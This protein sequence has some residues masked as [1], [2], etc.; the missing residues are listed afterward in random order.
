MPTVLPFK[1][2]NLPSISEKHDPE[3]STTLSAGEESIRDE[4]L[5]PLLQNLAQINADASEDFRTV[6]FCVNKVIPRRANL[7]SAWQRE[8][9]KGDW[10]E[11]H[12]E[13]K[14]LKKE[15]STFANEIICVIDRLVNRIGPILESNHSPDDKRACLRAFIADVKQHEDGATVYISKFDEFVT[16]FSELASGEGG[17]EGEAKFSSAPTR[18]LSVV[19]NEINAV[20]AT[21]MTLRRIMPDRTVLSAAIRKGAFP[22]VVVGGVGV[23][24]GL[25]SW[26]ALVL[27]PVIGFV[28]SGYRE[29]CS[30]NQQNDSD[31]RTLK[32]LKNAILNIIDKH[33]PSFAM[34]WNM[35]KVDAVR[36]V[37][38]LGN[39]DTIEARLEPTL[40]F[41]QVKEKFAAYRGTLDDYVLGVA[42]PAKS[43]DGRGRD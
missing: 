12:K 6:R 37:D 3:K 34:I 32:I 7:R 2:T 22:G 26:K 42:S 17:K 13:F 28:V 4:I 11:L 8:G 43:Q 23:A 5:Q 27:F 41:K 14:E 30:R 19:D 39:S 33:L 31:K 35:L 9:L 38:L 24:L 40:Y 15:S 21:L 36:L 16:R 29:I 18:L 1:T 20:E 10:K 25:L